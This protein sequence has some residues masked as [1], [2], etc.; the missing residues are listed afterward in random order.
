MIFKR[1][2]FASCADLPMYNF[3]KLVVLNDLNWLYSEPKRWYLRNVDLSDLW[4]NIFDEYTELSSDKQ[5][6]H[7]LEVMKDITRINGDLFIINSIVDLLRSAS[8]NGEN[9]SEYE[10][11]LNILRGYGFYFEYLN[12]TILED[13]NKVL[14]SAKTMLIELKDAQIEYD[15]INTSDNSKATEKDYYDTMGEL[16]KFQGH[17]IDTKLISVIDFIS[18]ISRFNKANA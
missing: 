5:G 3:I 8:K 11:S 1:K 13:C 16:S 15:K 14:N 2:T 7:I 18:L 17:Y 6:N 4:T 10:P 12:V 9:I